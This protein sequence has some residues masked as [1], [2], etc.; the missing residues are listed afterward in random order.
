MKMEQNTKINEEWYPLTNDE[1]RAY[2]ALYIIVLQI[3]KSKINMCW[4]KRKL[5]EMPIFSQIMFRKRFLVITHYLHFIDNETVSKEDKIRKV[6]SI[7]DYLNIRFQQLYILEENIV[8][9]ESLMKFR[10]WLN[11]IQFI[12]SKQ[13]RFGI[14]FYTLCESNFGYYYQFKNYTGQDKIQ[15]SD[16]PVS[17]SVGM[18]LV[19]P[20]LGIGYTLF[21]DNWYLSPNLFKILHEKNTNVVGTVSKNWKNMP[22]NHHH[23]S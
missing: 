20:I 8:M 9:D 15:G 10:G 23:I 17:E 14:K 12:A 16:E 2:F 1:V 5:L 13:A 11:Y 18:Q 22:K 4:S 19:E 21:L 6:Q 3:K 7:V